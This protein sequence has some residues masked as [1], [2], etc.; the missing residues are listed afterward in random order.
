[1]NKDLYG[2][3]I[4]LPED[5]IGYLKQCSDAV[6]DADT[7][8]EGFKRNQELRDSGYVTYQQ[9][10]RMK[11]FFDNFNGSEKDKPFILNGGYYVKDW[12]NRKL[13]S[14]RDG[15]ETS[16]DIK[17]IVLP[18]QH[19][20]THTKNNSLNP[21]NSHQSTLGKYGLKEHL[22]RINQLIK[23]TI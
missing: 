4:E 7:N 19:I 3:R 18:N 12:V 16:K 23:K 17:S 9:L 22:E 6:P 11:N 8:T 20:Q 2:E 10:G 13:N 21:N 5:V 15:I 14:M 1:V